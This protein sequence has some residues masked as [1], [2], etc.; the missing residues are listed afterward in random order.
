MSARHDTAEGYLSEIDAER[1]KIRPPENGAVFYTNKGRQTAEEYV[2]REKAAGRQASTLEQTEL[3]ARLHSDSLYNL[4]DR[5]TRAMEQSETNRIQAEKGNVRHQRHAAADRVWGHAS[6][7]YA[8]EASGRV[9]VITN[10]RPIKEYSFFAR[11]ERAILIRNEKVTHINGIE[12]KV[13]ERDLDR[14]ERVPPDQRDALRLQL[15]RRL[16]KRDPTRQKQPPWERHKRTANGSP[17][18]AKGKRK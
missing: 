5:N 2:A 11:H 9:T 12:R 1:E 13:L 8:Q 6:R 7:T 16:E 4:S 18:I 14:M 3:G 15:N 10:D 17:D